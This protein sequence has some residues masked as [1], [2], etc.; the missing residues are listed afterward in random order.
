MNS[1]RK[2][3]KTGGNAGVQSKLNISDNIYGKKDSINGSEQKSVHP[4]LEKDIGRGGMTIT[5]FLEKKGIDGGVAL[6]E[7]GKSSSS[8]SSI[9][10]DQAG[11]KYDIGRKVAAGGMGAI[12]QAKDLNI[13]RTVAMKVLLD[14]KRARDDQILRFIEE[15]QITGQ[16]EHPSIVP[17]HELGVDS[18]GNVFYTMKFIKGDNLDKILAGIKD[19]DA[20]LIAKYPLNSL[21][22]IFLKICEAMSFAHTK[23]VVHRDLKP[24]NV[25][26]GE[27][28]EALVMDWGLGKVIGTR[29][30]QAE[31]RGRK[32]DDR[33]QM[34]DDGKV[35]C[36][37]PGLEIDPGAKG[38]GIQGANDDSEGFGKDE[39]E[40]ARAAGGAEA[41][42]MTMEGKA[43][44]SP[45][46]M[47][48]EQAYGK[49]AEIDQ[50]TD[51]YSLGTILYQILTLHPPVEGD[52]IN[53]I[54]MKVAKGQIEPPAKYERSHL[55][56]LP[57]LPGKHIPLALSLVAMKALSLRKEDRYQDVKDLQKDIEAY[58]GGFATSAEK[59][60]VVKQFWLLAKR[61]KGF[62][63]AT[64]LVLFC[65]I[66]G[67]L[68]SLAQWRKAV[69]NERLAIANEKTAVAARKQ[70]EDAEKR[71]TEVRKKA[72]WDAY[73]AKIQ[74]ADRKISEGDILAAKNLLD[75]CLPRFRN[76][77]WGYLM[78]FCPREEASFNVHNIRI[79]EI[80]RDGRRMVTNAFYDKMLT[81]WDLWEAAEIRKINIPEAA[82][83]FASI[84]PDGNTIG[85]VNTNGEICTY[86]WESGRNLL[87]R[88]MKGISFQNILY[89]PDGSHAI[90]S[91]DL[92]GD[93]KFYCA[94]WNMKEGKEVFKFKETGRGMAISPDGKKVVFF[95]VDE[96]NTFTTKICDIQ[97][98]N[99]LFKLGTDEKYMA[100][101]PDGLRLVAGTWGGKVVEWDAVTGKIIRTLQDSG[102]GISSISYSPE[103]DYV[104]AGDNG[105]AVSVW[106]SKSGNRVSKLIG[107]YAFIKKCMLLPYSRNL[108]VASN[109]TT[110]TDYGVKIWP[111]QQSAQSFAV[112]FSGKKSGIG[113]LGFLDDGRTFISELGGKNGFFYEKGRWDRSISQIPVNGIGY[114]AVSRD[115]RNVLMYDKPNTLV[116]QDLQSKKNIW[117]VTQ[118]ENSLD[119]N[120]G[121]S[122]TERYVKAGPFIRVA[123]TGQVVLDFKITKVFWNNPHWIAF[124]PDDTSIVVC[125]GYELELWN[126][127]S[128]KLIRKFNIG[129]NPWS[130]SYSP[131]G[132]SLLIGYYSGY[133]ILLDIETGKSLWSA[134]MH[135]QAVCF[136]EFSPDGKRIISGSDD[137]TMKI[138]EPNS[139]NELLV[140]HGIKRACWGR[141]SPDQRELVVDNRTDGKYGFTVFTALD[142]TKSSEERLKESTENWRKRWSSQK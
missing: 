29:G 59:A 136:A 107:H 104:I 89:M 132:K 49:V 116:M 94:I 101:S 55:I 81:L 67:L 23:G 129:G 13:R 33:R 86:D 27:F 93:N 39:I 64:A 95:H 15:A 90:V 65:I 37:V 41:G 122:N 103:G 1:V 96:K 14:P 140:F 26:V 114:A 127:G 85:L 35:A 8:A 32:S 130:A 74:L 115:G 112:P 111:L 117:S 40:S 48:P 61:H 121:F 42:A 131:D 20:E 113:G 19:G 46:Y 58:Q 108:I 7:K 24:E 44:G 43:M 22:N 84:S 5:Q 38:K 110:E 97:T 56:S 124:S 21:L 98:G 63:T 16:M 51:I 139:Q 105:G 3:P 68:I 100:F 66:L 60:G 45:L 54:L 18:S 120:L 135:S 142:W 126:L 30:Q 106:D 80:S 141:F 91:G 82:M 50:R 99:S 25:M 92:E 133:V 70:A 109:E 125:N 28:G 36:A 87:N 76:W 119:M 47:A 10:V 31:D 83:S 102:I 77:E 17:V 2:A 53:A 118:E 88:R 137:K 52:S 11:R 4:T 128:R 9:L 6:D 12:L 62:V 34:T 73:V 71:E 134:K 57:H 79:C 138:W 78:G 123:A 72:E 75:S 69:N